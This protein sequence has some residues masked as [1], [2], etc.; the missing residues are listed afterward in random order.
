MIK[1]FAAVLLS[2]VSLIGPGMKTESQAEKFVLPAEAAVLVTVEGRGG[3]DCDI[4]VYEKADSAEGNVWQLR[5]KA[6]GSCGTGGFSDHRTEGDGTTP[7]GV[8]LLNTPFGQKP[9]MEGFPSDYVQVDES[10]VWTDTGNR[11]EKD[12]SLSGERVGSRDYQGFYDYVLDMGYNRNAVKKKGSALF[13][14]CDGGVKGSAGC[15]HAP[16]E[17]MTALMKLYGKYGYGRCFIAL[18]PEGRME[19]IYDSFGVN[20]GL[21][22]DGVVK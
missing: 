20:N 10:Y 5:M 6:D 14:H 2:L 7:V 9:A 22:P 3:L 17:L 4:C 12:V 16:E 8:F 21:C 13:I 19:R 11:L 1:A 18:A 15:I